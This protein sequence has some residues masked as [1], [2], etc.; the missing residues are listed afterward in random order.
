MPMYGSKKDKM[1]NKENK[2]MEDRT[3]IPNKIKPPKKVKYSH[4]EG[5]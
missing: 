3:V 1:K 2:S 4:D 5:K